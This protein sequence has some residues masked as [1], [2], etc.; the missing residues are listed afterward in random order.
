MKVEQELLAHKVVE[1]GIAACAS[2]V[3]YLQVRTACLAL[4]LHLAED[5]LQQAL[6]RRRRRRRGHWLAG[7]RRGCLIVHTLKQRAKLWVGE[8]DEAARIEVQPAVLSRSADRGP[9]I[10]APN[11]VGR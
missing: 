4:G 10:A 1:E 7:R 5:I 6:T 8:H 9:R 11:Q 3:R 2:R